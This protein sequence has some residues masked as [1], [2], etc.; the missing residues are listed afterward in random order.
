MYEEFFEMKNTPFTRSIPTDMLYRDRETDEIHNRL[1][2]AARK[3]LFAVLIG[4]SGAGKTTTLRR[5]KDALDGSE[6]SVLYLT[7]SK[8]TPRN[9]YNGLLERKRKSYR[10]VER[11]TIV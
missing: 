11:Q 2:Y 7:E 10:R 5:L 1:V 9:F 8:L 3:Q 4:D 6:F